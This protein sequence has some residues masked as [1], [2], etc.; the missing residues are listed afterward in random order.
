MMPRP[1][2]ELRPPRLAGLRA[3]RRRLRAD[4][5][6][7]PDTPASSRSR[8]RSSVTIRTS[9]WKSTDLSSFDLTELPIDENPGAPCPVAYS[10]D[11][12]DGCTR[13]RRRRRSK[14]PTV[15]DEADRGST[16]GQAIATTSPYRPG[17]STPRAEEDHPAPESPGGVE[18][19]STSV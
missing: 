10:S 15:G 8:A 19:S 18:P 17:H 1:A 16:L 12:D 9:G 11:H 6:A 3:R 13:D 14:S 5:P 4:G 7:R 2:D